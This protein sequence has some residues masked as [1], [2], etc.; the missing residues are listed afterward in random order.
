[1]SNLYEI[2]PETY[3]IRQIL[4]GNHPRKYVLCSASP[5][6]I[7]LRRNLVSREYCKPANALA[8]ASV[9]CALENKGKVIQ[10]NEKDNDKVVKESIRLGRGGIKMGHLIILLVEKGLSSIIDLNSEGL[11]LCNMKELKTGTICPHQMFKVEMPSRT[12]SYPT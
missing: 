12:D 6:F 10:E 5:S 3:K 1:M 9:H 8:S 2:Y 7:E 11:I 4:L